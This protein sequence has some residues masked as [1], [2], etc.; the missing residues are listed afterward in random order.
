M[1]KSGQQV[2]KRARKSDG[3]EIARR[4]LKGNPATTLLGFEAVSV[5]RGRA[6]LKL[7]VAARHLQLHGVVHGGILAALADTASAIAA[8]T[9]VPAGTAIATVELKINYLEA[10]PGGTVRAEA[11]VLR[12]GRNFLVVECGLIDGRGRLAAKALMT[13]GAARGHSL[14]GNRAWQKE[15]PG[16][17][18]ASMYQSLRRLPCAGL[19]LA[20]VFAFFAVFIYVFDHALEHQEVGATGPGQLD[21]IAIV[22]LDGAVKDFASVEDDGHGRTR[23]HLLNPIKI[24][25]VGG[26]GWG[27]LLAGSRAVVTAIAVR[28]PG[29]RLFLDVRETRT[30][31]PAVH[32]NYSLS[33]QVG[34]RHWL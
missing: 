16:L 6:V 10:V 15:T 24:L 17:S 25:C 31:H 21:A 18:P 23:L 28:D 33:L 1:V 34:L 2:E 19:L 7:E 3:L 8:Y 9:T 5:G 30:E 11:V 27:W 12:A 29:G 20:A 14:A 32:H 22:P 26:F 4:T 13:F